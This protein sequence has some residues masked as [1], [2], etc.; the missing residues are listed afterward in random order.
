MQTTAVQ[1]IELE[2]FD[3]LKIQSIDTVSQSFNARCLVRLRLIGAKA[4]REA[5]VTFK[6]GRATESVEWFAKQIEPYNSFEHD[7]CKLID[8]KPNIT[9]AGDDLL[10]QLRFEG[11]FSQPMWL[12]AFPFDSQELRIEFLILC[13][14]DGPGYRLVW[15]AAS[16]TGALHPTSSGSKP[17]ACIASSTSTRQTGAFSPSLALRRE[18]RG[19]PAST[20]PTSRSPPPSFPASPSPSSPRNRRS[21]WNAYRCRSGLLTEMCAPMLS[22]RFPLPSYRLPSRSS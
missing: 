9:D 10:I 5:F 11:R 8:E 1:E 3:V 4:R 13:R 19:S 15:K 18:W 12:H 6:D 14:V 17:G 20:S 21:L 7:S 22:S 2:R 16:W